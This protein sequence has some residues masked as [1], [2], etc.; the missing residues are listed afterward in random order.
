MWKKVVAIVVVAGAA[1]GLAIWGGGTKNVATTD[2]GSVSQSAYYSSLKKTSQGQQVLAN[3]IIKEVLEKKYASEVKDSDITSQYE[4]VSSQYGSSFASALSTNGLTEETFKENLRIQALEKAAVKANA[5]F[6]T[7]QLKAAYDDYTPTVNVSVIL[8]DTEDEAKAIIDKLNNGSDFAEL[9]KS[10]SKD[11]TTASNGGKMDGF[12]S[13]NTTLTSDFK[14][15]AFALKKGEY[16]TTPVQSTSPSGYYVIK[17]D[18]RDEKKSYASLKS[19]MKE[20]L[21]DKKMTDGDYV[22]AIVGKE[23][24][25]ANV[26]IKDSTLKSALTTYTTAA[27]SSQ[28]AAKSK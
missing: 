20:I 6:T 23:L 11:S 1:L 10:D 25:D 28:A 12:D 5:K 19:K 4:S 21:L 13:S 24:A 27:A 22:Q 7:K 17:M 2:A 18:S 15:A 3:M 26:N 9:A 14:K 16:T 8:T